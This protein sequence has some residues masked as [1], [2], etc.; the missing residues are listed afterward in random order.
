MKKP[1]INVNEVELQPRPPQYAPPKEAAERFD[2]RMGFVSQ[3][4]GAKKLSYNITAIP[5]GNKSAFP[6]HNH[7]INEEMF[8][9]LEGNGEV[10]IGTDVFPIK[11][12]DI[13]ACPPSGPEKAHQITNTGESELRYLALSTNI[14]PEIV[15]YP[16]SNKFGVLAEFNKDSAEQAQVFYFFGK[17]EQCLDYWEGE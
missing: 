16:D 3:A 9:I 2:A 7:R 10:R 14:T 15:D 5:P 1:I 17:Q 11:S 13:I 8:F 12:G 6:F 4:L